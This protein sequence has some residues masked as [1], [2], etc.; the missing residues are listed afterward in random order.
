MNKKNELLL[1]GI[2][3]KAELYTKKVSDTLEGFNAM[4]ERTKNEG[5]IRKDEKEYI[6]E[7]T[8]KH[9]AA[10]RAVLEKAAST[11]TS[12][13]RDAAEE[14]R[15]QL[16]DSLS[17]P[18]PAAVIQQLDILS[19]FHIKPTKTQIENLIDLNGGNILGL[20]A[21]SSVLTA[22]GSEYKV[23]FYDVADY[24]ADLQTMER[25]A[26]TADHYVPLPCHH[27][28]CMVYDGQRR[29]MT[30]PDGTR[31]ASGYTW[32]SVSLIG[33]QTAFDS[34]LS[35]I[36]EMTTRWVADVTTVEM[37]EVSAKI[38]EEEAEAARAAGKD[39]PDEHD[40]VSTVTI[41]KTDDDAIALAKKIGAERA[42]N[43]SMAQVMRDH[44]V[45]L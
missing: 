16:L 24:E 34:H 28:G 32:D 31:Y 29:E 27:A 38:K 4:M 6:R 25:V 12:E 39:I 10:T 7:N 9:T 42:G 17:H 13:V 41:E 2:K 3:S 44:Y 5:A 14:L 8:A 19:K 26:Q 15:N 18:V 22:S 43:G 21:I 20:E 33:N 40:P 23:N 1:Q 11:F 37:N 30:R 36:D 35:K 45:K